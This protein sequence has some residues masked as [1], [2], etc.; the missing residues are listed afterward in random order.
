MPGGK[1]T[2][3]ISSKNTN[4]PTMRRRG[5]GSRRPTSKPPRSR[6]RCSMTASIILILLTRSTHPLQY[7]RR[8]LFERLRD[9]IDQRRATVFRRLAQDRAE[10][11][12][13]VHPPRSDAVAGCDQR[14]IGAREIDRKV[15]LAVAC[16]LAR[17]DPAVGRIREHDHEKRHLVADHGLELT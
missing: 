13:I 8:R 12:R 2:G 17:L 7:G 4:G 6:R 1:S 3:P 11:F 9:D 5:C 14:M 16:P 10:L 15:A